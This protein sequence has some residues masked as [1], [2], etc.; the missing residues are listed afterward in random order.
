MRRSIH[1]KNQGYEFEHNFGH[2]ERH[3]TRRLHGDRVFACLMKLAF[4]IDQ[5]HKTCC[6]RF[7]AAQARAERS[8]A[9]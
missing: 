2:C 7:Q 1:K 8:L 6:P 5:L 4:G 9:A 3:R